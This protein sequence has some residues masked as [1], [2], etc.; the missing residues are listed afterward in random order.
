MATISAIV[1]TLNEEDRI[2]RCLKSLEGIAGEIVVV[3]SFSADSTAEICS[4]MG[5]RVY[6]REF[7]G[8]RDQK[9]YAT[10][11]A[12][13]DHIISIDADEEISP[14]LRRSLLMIINQDTLRD[15]YTM[16]RLNICCGKVVKHSGLYPDRKIRIFNRTNCRWGEYNVHERVIPG[17]GTRGEHLKGNLIHHAYNSFDDFDRKIRHYSVISAREYHY[18]GKRTG[19]LAPYLHMSWR[20]FR[21]YFLRRGMFAG[22]CGYRICSITAKGVYLKY[23]ELRRLQKEQDRN[24]E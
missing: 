24:G 20:F 4:D 1:I 7:T 2:G 10:S 8:Y 15:Y 18:A 6:T 23:K 13:N 3:D 21:N 22:R 17:K 12:V 5:A 14:D 9:E 11:L 16:N 19:P